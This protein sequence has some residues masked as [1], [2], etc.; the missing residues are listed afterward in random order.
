MVEVVDEV[1]VDVD[2]VGT[3]LTEVDV[4]SATDVLGPVGGVVGGLLG[5]VLGGVEGGVEG[6]VVGGVLGGVLGGVDG[7]SVGGV[8]GGL[9]GSALLGGASETT[10][11]LVGATGSGV[12]IC[13]PFDAG[14]VVAVSGCGRSGVGLNACGAAGEPATTGVATK[15]TTPIVAAAATPRVRLASTGVRFGVRGLIANPC[16]QSN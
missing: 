13:G 1:D 2:V 14:F 7:G 16:R 15:L 3:A 10:G 9:V 6:G 5:G 8:E 12:L 4:E 11:W